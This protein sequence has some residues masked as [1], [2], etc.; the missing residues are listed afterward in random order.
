MDGQPGA[1]GQPVRAHR[2]VAVSQDMRHLLGREIHIEGLGW[3]YVN[4]TMPR[5]WKRRIDVAVGDVAQARDF[6][7]QQAR[8]SAVHGE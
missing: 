3:R 8:I 5:K 4:D 1:L 2:T 6:G 7:K